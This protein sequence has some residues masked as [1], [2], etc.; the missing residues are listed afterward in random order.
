MSLQI[1][2]V[3]QRQVQNRQVQNRKLRWHWYGR[4]SGVTLII[5]AV[6]SARVMKGRAA[7]KTPTGDY[8]TQRERQCEQ[9]VRSAQ[10]AAS[11]N[12]IRR[13]W[14]KQQAEQHLILQKAGIE[15]R[16]IN[17]CKRQG[18]GREHYTHAAWEHLKFYIPLRRRFLS[19]KQSGQWVLKEELTDQPFR[20]RVQRA[21]RPVARLKDAKQDAKDAPA[22][23]GRTAQPNVYQVPMSLHNFRLWEAQASRPNPGD[24]WDD[25][26]SEQP[27]VLKGGI[28][29][30]NGQSIRLI[31]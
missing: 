29:A 7:V 18:A 5:V 28:T 31:R 26:Y 16:F 3:L 2:V 17:D 4:V 19:L 6:F 11:D 25:V 20:S 27:V 9:E 14:T 22:L 12:L 21:Q 23:P 30:E 10:D 15:T 13:V 8:L 24:F 1:R